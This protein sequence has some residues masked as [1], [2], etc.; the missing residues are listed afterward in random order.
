[1]KGRGRKEWRI[2]DIKHILP[3]AA[4][5]NYVKRKRFFL[6][7]KGTLCFSYGATLVT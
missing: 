1:L 4:K 7:K 3:V 5:S 2:C 6:F